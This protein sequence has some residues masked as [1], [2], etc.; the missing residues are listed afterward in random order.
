MTAKEFNNKYKDYLEKGFHGLDIS[1]EKVVNCLDKH[2][3]QI[4]KNNMYAFKYSQISLE[5]GYCCIYCNALPTI[6]VHLEREID[7]ILKNEK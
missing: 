5:H 1:N 7:Q 2:F 6:V 3:E 4:I